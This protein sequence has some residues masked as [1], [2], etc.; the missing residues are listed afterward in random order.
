MFF[1]LF[2]LTSLTISVSH[3]QTPSQTT[4]TPSSWTKHFTTD[5]SGT[6]VDVCDTDPTNAVC[7]CPCDSDLITFKQTLSGSKNCIYPA[8]TLPTADY[9]QTGRSSQ[10]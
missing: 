9:N 2:M 8:D 7:D 4:T 1:Q 3:A 10:R 5:A 6:A